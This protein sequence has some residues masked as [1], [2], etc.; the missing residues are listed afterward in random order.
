MLQPYRDHFNANFTP[1]AY[2]KLIAQLNHHT[3]TTSITSK[4]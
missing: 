1:A 4:P 3:R 2:E